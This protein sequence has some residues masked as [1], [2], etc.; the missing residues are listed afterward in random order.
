L[1]SRPIPDPPVRI[2]P[3]DEPLLRAQLDAMPDATLA[4]YCAPWERAQG[5]RLSVATMHRAIARLGWTRKK[6]FRATEQDP[7][8]RAAWWETVGTL[9]AQDLVFVDESSATIRLTR[10]YAR[11]PRNKRAVGRVPRNHG[12][13]TTVVTALSPTGLQASHTCIGALNAE[14][15]LGYVRDV[16]CPTLRLGQIVTLDNLTIHKGPD[17]R[18]VSEAAECTLLFLPPYSP[19]FAPIELAFAQIKAALR[20]TAARTQE[21]LDNA[22]AAALVRVRAPDA[23]NYFTHCGYSFAQLSRNLL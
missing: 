14:T 11:A 9:C 21:A 6:S 17:V 10:L 23:R 3:T 2:D 8:K 1:T 5:V 22:I 15:F 12:R 19:D 13:A 16:L 4:E 18:R 20:A 7:V